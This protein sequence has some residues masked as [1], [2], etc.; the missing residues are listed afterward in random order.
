[1]FLEIFK[2]GI[3]MTEQEELIML[4]ALVE[5]QKKEIE[6]KDETIRRQNIQIEGMLQALLHAK[7]QR[8]G[9]SSEATQFPGQLSL[10]ETNE[11]LV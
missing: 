5:K 7:K 10:F 6:K 8:F 2:A 1:M 4:R 9:R 3:P 11:E